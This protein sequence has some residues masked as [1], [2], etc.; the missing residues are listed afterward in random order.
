LSFGIGFVFIIFDKITM[1]L[2]LLFFQPISFTFFFGI[3][4]LKMYKKATQ[5]PM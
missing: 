2:F 5:E 3:L 1:L 4:I